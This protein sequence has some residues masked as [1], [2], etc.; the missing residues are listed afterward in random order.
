MILQD[1]EEQ[2][3]GIFTFDDDWHFAIWWT[4]VWEVI[5]TTDCFTFV[6]KHRFITFIFP[7]EKQENVL[8]SHSSGH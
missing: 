4:S 5:G 6:K 8:G 7:P 1:F 3:C 2:Q